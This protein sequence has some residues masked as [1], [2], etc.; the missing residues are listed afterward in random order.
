MQKPLIKGKFLMQ[1]MNMKGGWTYVILPSHQPKTGLPFGWFIVK[2]SID[3]YQI[4]QYKLW[5][6]ADGKLFLPVKSEIRKK[7]KKD[8]GDYIDV[9]LYEDRSDIIIPDELILCLQDFP[10]A[11]DFFNQLSDTSK[12]QYVDHIYGTKNLETRGNRISKA[13]EK[14]ELGLKWHEKL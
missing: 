3:T 4:N 1:K 2:G 6:T 8:V 13:I 7:I 9:V 5:P 14:L 11:L 10:Q 12:K